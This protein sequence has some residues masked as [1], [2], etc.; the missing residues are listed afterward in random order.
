MFDILISIS[1]NYKIIVF[2]MLCLSLMS[3]GYTKT[4]EDKYPEITLFSELNTER[5]LL[6][7]ENFDV[8]E[9]HSFSKGF[10][11][12]FKKEKDVF[13][14]RLDSSY[15]KIDSVKISKD[16][17]VASDGFIY[18]KTEADLI[19]KVHYYT[20]ESISISTH[21][22]SAIDFYNHKLDSI[23]KAQPIDVTLNDSLKRQ[24]KGEHIANAQ[25][26]A[27]EQFTKEVLP[28]LE[29]TKMVGH[30]GFILQYKGIEQAY[31][32]KVKRFWMTDYSVVF[33]KEQLVKLDECNV[34]NGSSHMLDFS[35][36]AVFDTA[37][38]ANG[39][40]GNHYVFSF[41]P[42]EIRYYNL[43]FKGETIQFKYYH[44]RPSWHISAEL[45]P[46]G[47]TLFIMVPGDGFYR[48]LL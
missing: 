18:F 39:S 35:E 2:V 9:I 10:V 34:S 46:D 41:H 25:W 40:S 42:K 32:S 6:K 8:T 7:K 44:E 19:K 36:L 37:V 17:S 11:T 16:Y 15:N 26:L 31:I 20:H 24:R 48:V 22:F 47:E 12:V 3:C 30:N 43:D 4:E 27:A 28:G 5:V 23:S 21:E 45:S 1:R 33:P 38:Y 29:C 14:V 13:A